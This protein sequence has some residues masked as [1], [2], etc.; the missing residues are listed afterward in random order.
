MQGQMINRG[1]TVNAGSVII[2]LTRDVRQRPNQSRPVNVYSIRP[3]VVLGF[4]F[5]IKATRQTSPVGWP[6]FLTAPGP[7]A[8][9]GPGEYIRVPL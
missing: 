2:S 8:G 1:L 6:L 3:L 9:Q 5:Y 7:Y 4:G